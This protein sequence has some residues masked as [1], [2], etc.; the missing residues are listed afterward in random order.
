MIGELVRLSPDSCSF[1]P[2]ESANI[3]TTILAQAASE[4]AVPER[5]VLDCDVGLTD[6][7]AEVA[8][9]YPVHAALARYGSWSG[10]A[11]PGLLSTAVS[12]ANAA[13][14]WQALRCVLGLLGAMHASA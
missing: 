11:A 8:P 14:Q 5:I 12:A 7:A 9:G 13:E 10:G 3:C 2:L 1:P 6:R 4:R